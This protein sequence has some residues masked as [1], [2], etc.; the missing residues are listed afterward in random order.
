MDALVL[1]KLAGIILLIMG[2]AFFVGSEIALTS[3][4]RS[5]IRQL[6]L[7]GN[8]SAKIVQ[9][10]HTEPERFYSVTQIGITLMSLALGAIGIST[11]TT[12]LDPVIDFVVVHLSILVPPTSAHHVAHTTAQIVAFIFISALHIVGGELA[13]KV[14]AFH[15]PVKLSLTVARTINFLYRVLY[16]SIWFLNHAANGLLRLFGQRDPAG[17]RGGHFSI[18]EEE[19]RII[20]SASESEGVLA[21]EETA[22]I[23]GVFDLEEHRVEEIMVPRTRIV[24]IPHQATVQEAL[25]IFRSEKHHRYPVVDTSI[26]NIV[27]MLPIKELL[28][29]YN[30]EGQPEEAKRPI[31]EIML[32]PY[33][34]PAT[35]PVSVLLKEFKARRK[36]M[37]IVIDEFGGTAGLITLED[38]L[39][40]I[41]GEYEDEFSTSPVLITNEGKQGKLLIDASIRLDVLQEKIDYSFPPGEYMT[42]AGFIYSHLRRVPKPGDKVELPGCRFVVEGMDGHLITRVS[43]EPRPE[44]EEAERAEPNEA[45]KAE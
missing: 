45:E 31:R 21:P 15:R 3:A 29:C 28:N 35:M 39:E 11:L 17:P 22:M 2:N 36:Q 16:S 13:P 32:S 40:E 10:L 5:R 23:R 4:R 6:A 44:R 1:A 38:V 18:S 27:G 37:A 25:E 34:V 19:L 33:L 20:L 43:F 41:V 30:P 14:Y 8:S 26:D 7:E 42:L 24:A 9:V 12:V